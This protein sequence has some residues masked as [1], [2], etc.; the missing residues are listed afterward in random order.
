LKFADPKV[1]GSTVNLKDRVRRAITEYPCQL[2]F[3]HRDAEHQDHAADRHL[4]IERAVQSEAVEGVAVVPVRMSEAWLLID[5]DAIRRGADNPNGKTPLELPP[6]S[7]LE[8]IADPKGLL[9]SLLLAASEKSG[10]RLRAFNDSGALSA[11]RTRVAELIEDY[12]PLTAGSAFQ[13]VM[14]A[15]SAAVAKVWSRDGD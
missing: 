8:A 9:T 15:T 13:D 12:S 10:R 7:R 5:A 11:R 4:E 6:P 14:S 3:V 2:L 1:I